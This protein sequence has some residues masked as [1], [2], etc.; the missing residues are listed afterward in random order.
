ME[1]ALKRGE[2][3]RGEGFS[4]EVT[5]EEI[6]A[7]AER[8]GVHTPAFNYELEMG[9]KVIRYYEGEATF[10]DLV[11]EMA[12]LYV[13]GEMKAGRELTW[14]S[15]NL[16]DTQKAFKDQGVKNWKLVDESFFA[17]GADAGKREKAVI[18]G[19]SKL[20]Q[21]VFMGEYRKKA[22]PAPVKRFLEVMEALSRKVADMVGLAGAFRK[23]VD[24]G[25][26][27]GDFASFV[28]DAVGADFAQ[29]R[30]ELTRK[31]FENQLKEL[32]E[33]PERLL[34]D[35]GFHLMYAERYGLE[36]YRQQ[37]MD[38]LLANDK[39]QREREFAQAGVDFFQL[40]KGATLE[41]AKTVLSFVKEGRR[42]TA[43]FSVADKLDEM[44]KDAGK[45]KVMDFVDMV[46]SSNVS[47]KTELGVVE[48]RNVTAQE[49]ADIKAGLGIDVTGMVHEFTAG[50][51]VHAL[52]KHSHDS[53]A[54]KGQLDLT[55]EDIKLALDVLDS[56]DRMEFK[57]K[58][59]NQSSV[60]YVKQYPHGEI[61]TVE[62]VIET[63][64][65]RY[66]KK[67]RLTFK[68]AWVK[69]TSSG[70]GPGIEGVYTPQRRKNS[71]A[72]EGGN[73]NSVAEAQEQGLFRDGHFEADN[74]VITE[75]GVTF[76]I[77][78]LHASP[79]SFRK[80]STD[81]MGQG[82]GAQAYG[83]GLYFAESPKV[84]RRYMNQFGKGLR[85]FWKVNGKNVPVNELWKVVPG[86][87]KGD[88]PTFYK[89]LNFLESARKEEKTLLDFYKFKKNLYAVLAERRK[90]VDQEK[91][92]RDIARFT[93]RTQKK[94]RKERDDELKRLVEGE[95][96][97]LED[98]QEYVRNAGLTREW[99][100]AG[101]T[102][103]PY[104][105]LP[106]NYRVE[107]NV[108]DSVLLNWD[109]PFSEQSETVKE[110]LAEELAQRIGCAKEVALESL[111]MEGR[112]FNGEQIYVGLCEGFSRDWKKGM[113][114]ASLA[115]R[116]FGVK[117]IRYADG[118]SRRKAEEEQTYNYVIFDGN[119][120]KIT[121]FADES[122][123]GEWAD[124]VD[125]SATFSVREDLLGDMKR[126]MEKTRSDAVRE[127]WRHVTER[128]PGFY[129][130]GTRRRGV[131]QVFH[132]CK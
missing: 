111:L 38:D 23:A 81:Y 30:S 43:S 60:I 32:K 87:R 126:Q 56:Y 115:L 27:K 89:G 112:Q 85:Q 8:E 93:E 24:S 120:I 124:Y 45:R 131:F 92:E 1:I 80:F 101:N 46:V 72:N 118:F 86:V 49:I 53:S 122:T 109:K 130:H 41:E 113:K 83:W 12:E 14:F 64:G 117:G 69:S 75:P 28:Y 3:A 91:F 70:T 52:K 110:A 127:Y 94:K 103:E 125:G 90:T 123:G 50:G 76:S 26:V 6:A 97:E 106:S 102:V 105:A 39:E 121:A 4:G 62:Q 20:M 132:Y 34:Q 128:V 65:R 7:V 73:V 96:R 17:D 66:S 51:I 5:E 58:G 19:M 55:K 84:N 31:K 59:R 25:T 78:A 100:E 63:T 68:T 35:Y 33:K 54:R 13:K 79:H 40:M 74:A 22:L 2:L 61:H 77:T 82:E 10:L 47:N 129:H 36:N 114:K 57:P 21:A 15:R 44:G 29:S 88:V 107:L 104:A 99:A 9:K 37:V 95:R 98:I 48:Y 108:D 71:M 42:E 18:E 16:L 119:D 116:K 11:E 67:P